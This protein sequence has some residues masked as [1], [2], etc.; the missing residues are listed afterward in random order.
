M[1][2]SKKEGGTIV[3]V[4]VSTLYSNVNDMYMYLV[5]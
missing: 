3:F 4:T 5:F 2:L 1:Y